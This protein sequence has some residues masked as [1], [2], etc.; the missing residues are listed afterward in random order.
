MGYSGGSW[1]IQGVHGVFEVVPGVF[2]G[3][4]GGSSG[5][6]HGVFWVVHGIY[7]GVGPWGIWVVHGLFEEGGSMGYSW[8]LHWVL[9]GV[10]GVFGKSVNI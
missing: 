9:G 1:G 10:P 7:S 5:D 2:I 4:L 8:G 6:V 3:Y